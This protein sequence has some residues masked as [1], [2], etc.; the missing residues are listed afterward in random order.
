MKFFHM[1]DVHLG[2]MP[3]NRFAW[4]QDRGREIYESF[5]GVLELAAKENVD[6]VFISGDL[7]HRQPLK[8]ELKEINYH[9]EKCAPTKIVIIAGNHDYIGSHSNYINYPWSNNV[10][11]MDSASCARLHFPEE[12]VCIYGFSYHHYEIEERV[13]DG[14][15]PVKTDREGHKLPAEC[16]HVL[17]AHGG[18]E[19]HI[20]IH[21]KKLELAGFDYVALG[22][23]HKPGKITDK[24]IYAGALEPIDKNDVGA[25]GFVRG[26]F[27]A[28]GL[29]TEF[30]SWAKRSYVDVDI[31]VT[32]RMSWEAI[33]DQVR[34]TMA[35][36]GLT[37]L[38]KV[39]LKGNKD[40]DLQYDLQELFGLGNV[41]DVYD[42]MSYEF[43]WDS[44]YAANAGNL[45]GRF[46]KKVMDSDMDDSMRKKVLHYGFNALY[47]TGEKS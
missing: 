6:F 35:G 41:V 7:F 16:K 38:F 21:F 3:E 17:L 43:D 42:Q 47:R 30:V 27:D 29:H 12:N 25:H 44:L 31:E 24:M 15:G 28:S 18:D 11:F 37:N 33:K 26:F 46:I 19:K 10:Y 36:A 2:A 32:S 9:F 4:G 20:P 22:H 34:L 1:A 8:R 5:Y 13:Y 14:V 23:I 45:L 40:V 39:T